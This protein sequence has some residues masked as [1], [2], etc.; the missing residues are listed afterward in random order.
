MVG[1]R[2]SGRS[3]GMAAGTIWYRFDYSDAL[4][5]EKKIPEGVCMIDSGV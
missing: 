2:E 5:G 1:C 3:E 4:M